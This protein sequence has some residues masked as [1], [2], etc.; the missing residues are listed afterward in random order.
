MKINENL[1]SDV[2]RSLKSDLKSVAVTVLLMFLCI[3][4]LWTKYA[5]LMCVEVDG[6]SMN[7][8]LVTGDLL[9]ADRISGASRGD[10]V[11]FEYNGKRYIKRLIAVGG[12]TVRIKD[13]HVYLKK[14]GERDFT[15]LVE[16]YAKG[17]TYTTNRAVFSGTDYTVSEGCFF[18]L[19]DNRQNS[20]DSR[21]FG[22][23]PFSSL[24]GKVPQSII[25]AKDTFW[26]RFFK[27]L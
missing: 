12:D 20:L 19:G 3:A 14:S 8:T 16:D 18:A 15:L 25:D 23:V 5:W 11:V 10:V 7:D 4:I 6:D 27:Y 24:I 22:E 17:L 9:L 2:E 26:N 21:A 1:N 13:S